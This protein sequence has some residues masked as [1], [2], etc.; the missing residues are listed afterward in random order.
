MKGKNKPSSRATGDTAEQI[1]RQYLEKKGYSII[2]TNWYYGHL[3]LDIIARENDELVI[4]EVKSRTGE[5]FSHPS[6]ALS[7]KK[8]K[9]IIEA[10]DAWVQ[11]TGWKGDARFDLIIIVFT[12]PDSYEL[13]HYD[14]AFNSTLL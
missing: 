9:Q 1:A 7:D 2:H 11:L 10:A 3:E 14:N 12:G 8:M 13:E 6:E 5:G 4:V